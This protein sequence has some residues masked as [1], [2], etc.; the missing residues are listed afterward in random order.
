MISSS[1]NISLSVGR[2]R[3][4][5]SHRTLDP[6]LWNRHPETG[7]TAVPPRCFVALPCVRVLVAGR[8]DRASREVVVAAEPDR[9][10]IILEQRRK[11]LKELRR[12]G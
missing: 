10:H 3:L 8:V 11:M 6:Q 2:S 5:I 9:A 7:H 4:F 12:E 1:Q